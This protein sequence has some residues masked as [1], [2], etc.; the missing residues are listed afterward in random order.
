MKRKRALLNLSVILLT[1]LGVPLRA[2]VVLTGRTHCYQ[3]EG[4]PPGAWSQTFRVEVGRAVRNRSGS[5]SRVTALE[6]GFKAVNPPLTYFNGFAGAAY[7]VSAEDQETGSAVEISLVGNSFGTDT[8]A[9]DGI[10]GLWNLSYS[11]LLQPARRGLSTGRIVMAK[12]FKPIGRSQTDEPGETSLE[13]R[14]LSEIRC[15]P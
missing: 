14:S 9:S 3:V 12:N 4:N 2:E 8:G 5:L 13:V 7:Y 6:Q 1:A 11:M 15:R 10:P